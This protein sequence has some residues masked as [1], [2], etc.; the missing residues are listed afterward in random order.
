MSL[1]PRNLAPGKEQFEDFILTRHLTRDRKEAKRVQYDYRT[2][3][4]ELFSCVAKT[5]DEA[6]A[7]RDAW[8]AEKAA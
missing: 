5:L 8:L 6:R 4:G 2:P 7:R 1:D 3:A